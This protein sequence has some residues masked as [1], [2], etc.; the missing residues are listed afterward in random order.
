MLASMGFV[1]SL[2]FYN[3]Y[4]PEIA[5]PADQDRVS[6]KGFAF[7]YIGSVLLQLIG[8]ALSIADTGQGPLYRIAD[9]LSAGRH[10]VGGFCADHFFRVAKI[11]TDG[12]GPNQRIQDGFQ[13]G[14][15]GF[16][17]G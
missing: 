16:C 4:L 14:G 13:R 11:E 2:V 3:A 10:L 8:F 6:A 5:A 15:E 12:G 1:G 9:H 17:G 7:G